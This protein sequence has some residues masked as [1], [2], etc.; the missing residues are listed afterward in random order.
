M[1][2]III[3]IMKHTG[4]MGASESIATVLLMASITDCCSA[5]I[6]HLISQMMINDDNDDDQIHIRTH[7]LPQVQVQAREQEQEQEQA[8]LWSSSWAWEQE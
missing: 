3:M 8:L 4:E 5:V 2:M 6:L 7:I 1:N